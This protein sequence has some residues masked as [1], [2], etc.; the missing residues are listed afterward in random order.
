MIPSYHLNIE[1]GEKLLNTVGHGSETNTLHPFLCFS[2]WWHLNA[3]ESTVQHVGRRKKKADLAVIPH[4]SLIW[5]IDFIIVP[6]PIVIFICVGGGS[7]KGVLGK[8]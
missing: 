5:L 6:Y 1:L 3:Q 4:C 8:N 7:F 2:P